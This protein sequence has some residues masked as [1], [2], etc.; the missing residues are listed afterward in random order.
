MSA[1]KKKKP[2]IRRHLAQVQRAAPA[3]PATSESKLLRAAKVASTLGVVLL[4]GAL[5][6]QYKVISVDLGPSGPLVMKIA[7][8]GLIIAGF[9]FGRGAKRG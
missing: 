5:A 1:K 6:I 7:G 3:Q 2:R 9:V 8:V 4:L